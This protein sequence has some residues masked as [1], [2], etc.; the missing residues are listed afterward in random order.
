MSGARS[1]CFTT[2]NERKVLSCHR[3]HIV[4]V[5]EGAI[6]PWLHLKF[7][8]STTPTYYFFDRHFDP[9]TKLDPGKA[10]IEPKIVLPGTIPSQTF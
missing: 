10:A 8:L 2:L 7:I 3:V 1:I 9:S 5:I 4:F 6:W